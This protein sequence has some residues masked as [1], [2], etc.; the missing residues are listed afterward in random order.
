M[1]SKAKNVGNVML[2]SASEMFLEY[3]DVFLLV[4]PFFVTFWQSFCHIPLKYFVI[5]IS[6]SFPTD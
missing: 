2:I 6:I 3:H 5:E 4:R 1:A